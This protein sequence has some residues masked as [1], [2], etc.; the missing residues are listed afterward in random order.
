MPLTMP[1]AIGLAVSV[2]LLSVVGRR[3]ALAVSTV[4]AVAF[5][6]LVARA[7]SRHLRACHYDE[8]ALLRADGAGDAWVAR[9]RAGLNRLASRLRA[10]Y[11]TSIA[12]GDTI[13]AGFSDLRFTDASRV[14]FPF[15]SVM[16]EK[17]SVCSV[18]TAS[19]GPHLQNLD[20]HWTL[21]VSGSY[22]VNV[23]GFDRYK[24]WID[25]G[26]ARV[27]DL[28]P[29]L[30][31]LHP[32]V[33]E[34][35]AMLQQVSGLDEASFHMSGTEAVMAAVRMARFSTRRRLIVC[36]SGAYH[37]WWDGVQPGL[38]SERAIDDCLTLKD[39]HPA[40]LAAIRRRAREIAAV[41]V[42]PIQAFHPNSPP[43]NDAVLLTSDA[44]RMQESTKRY[45]RWLG[46]LREVCTAHGV[47][48]IFDEVYT[49]FRLAPRGAQ[50]YFG[51]QADMV[52]YGKTLGGGLP[53]GVVC[54]RS[55][56]MRRAD[57]E[58]PMRMAYVVGTFS[59]HP[60]VMGAMNEFLRWAIEPGTV[61]AY[62][63]MNASCSA[64]VR[65]T[66][67]RLA[68]AS[69]PVRLV[70]LGTIWTVLFTETSRYNWL[71]QYYL[72]AEGI[73]LS[74]VGTG[75]CVSSMD[76]TAEDYASLQSRLLDAVRQM[77]SDGWWLTAGEY[78]EKEKRMRQRLVREIV[79]GLVPVPKPLQTF[80][81]AV[82]Q[83]KE[84]DHHASHNNW[85]N[86]YLHLVSSSIFIYCYAILL[87][88]LTQ[89]MFL[90]L[91]SLFV[92]Q[93]GHAVLEPACHD[94]EALL[95][96]YNTRNKTL[97]V[98]GYTLIPLALMARAGT[99]S[100]A[101]FVSLADQ[102]AL[103]WFGW[104]VLVV[105]GRVLVLTWKHDFGTAM[106]WFVKLVTDPFTDIVA[107]FPRRT[108]R[109]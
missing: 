108:Q 89:A 92:R 69:L 103:A 16:R 74:W 38:G 82:K 63:E 10:Q 32:I 43:P 56:L 47:P 55:T 31:P 57:P 19:R 61:G 50:A 72:R 36:F 90:G 83:R 12:W 101:G 104:T 6:P 8:E 64:W 106:I 11:A 4:P 95:L 39:L 87:V 79:G 70:N 86:Q 33:G 80:Y 9:R 73:T 28:G 99:W 29:V 59:A 20:G 17:F 94:E 18:V 109:A 58:R 67:V 97:I 102:I 35:I 85:M 40:S 75:R 23:A 1:E 26:W 15:V 48:L 27:R 13:R 66:N 78:P 98:L 41:L 7:L 96:G 52:V 84:D 107:Y 21:D 51:I 45:A 42:N 65:D 71:L 2:L 22:G 53:I 62:D 68:E 34:N 91:A 3:L 60:A 30:G 37:G 14:P 105:L 77:Q 44:R 93:F 46:Q 54:G 100:L 49:G 81:S 5:M 24:T 25:R 88:D 76:F